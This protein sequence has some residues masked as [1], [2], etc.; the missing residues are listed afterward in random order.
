MKPLIFW[1]LRIVAFPEIL[2]KKI[3]LQTVLIGRSLYFNTIVSKE[4]IIH[5][6]EEKSQVKVL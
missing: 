4:L 3:S 1:A 5:L 6:Q 2:N